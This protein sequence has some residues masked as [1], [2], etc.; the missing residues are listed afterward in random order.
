[1]NKSYHFHPSRLIL[2]LIALTF[3]FFSAPAQKKMPKYKLL[4]PIDSNTFCAAIPTD[5][6]DYKWGIIDRNE[7]IIVPFNFDWAIRFS[8]DYASVCKKDGNEE[9]LYGVVNRN[10]E[11]IL[12]C[13]YE[14]VKICDDNIA[15]LRTE[16]DTKVINL[17]TLTTLSS[18][19]QI[20]SN[21]DVCSYS[22]G[23]IL[24]QNMNTQ[25]YGFLNLQGQI[26]IPF[27]YDEA[28]DFHDGFAVVTFNN[29][30]R[31]I[32]RN[33]NRAFGRDFFR[34]EYDGMDDELGIFNFTNGMAV[35]P[36]RIKVMDA[37]SFENYGMID[38]SGKL[39]IPFDYD[40]I[41]RTEKG[42][43]LAYK[44][45]YDRHHRYEL[46]HF[47]DKTGKLIKTKTL[48]DDE[49]GYDP[50]SDTY[51][52]RIEITP[53]SE[54]YTYTIF[55]AEG[56]ILKDY[57]IEEIDET[58]FFNGHGYNFVRFAGDE[59]WSIIDYNGNIIFRNIA[60]SIPRYFFPG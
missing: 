3:I 33:G 7:H 43:S 15:M 12:P 38:N 10:G 54:E 25:K 9:L 47:F 27:I 29:R 26:V 49:M 45:E 20:N 24:A 14:F 42:E 23:L 39:I 19:N 48:S 51:I 22:E 52:K 5:G 8:G 2:G 21:L 34:P 31:F 55:N 4:Y 44:V 56:Q 13:N 41:N 59:D 37:P 35:V 60:V 17:N 30:L 57:T 36:K 58:G 11:E 16:H 53:D 46:N 40:F 6:F 18:L 1:M 50:I 28:S 32:D